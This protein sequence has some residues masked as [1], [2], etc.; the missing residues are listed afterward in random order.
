MGIK[1]FRRAVGAAAAMC[2]MAQPVGG[3]SRPVSSA[4]AVTNFANAK[5]ASQGSAEG[6]AVIKGANASVVYDSELKSNVLDLHGDSFGGGWL[7]LPAMFAKVSDKGFSF[8]LKFTP[9]FTTC[10][11]SVAYASV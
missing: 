8:S 2:V 9:I 5:V 1:I 7:Q 11:L 6:D 10:L 4:N 3:L